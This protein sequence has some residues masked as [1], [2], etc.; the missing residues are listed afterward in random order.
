MC[1]FPITLQKSQKINEANDVQ[2]KEQSFK[3]SKKMKIGA[4]ILS[5][6]SH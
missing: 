1:K 4:E 6:S 3:G 2:K 5:S